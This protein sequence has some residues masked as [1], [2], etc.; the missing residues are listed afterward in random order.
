MNIQRSLVSQ[1]IK[2]SITIPAE[3]EYWDG[4]VET[5][6]GES[7]RPIN[8]KFN[9]PIDWDKITEDAS[10]ALAE[11]YMDKKVEL[12]DPSRLQELVVNVFGNSGSFLRDNKFIGNLF[13][14]KNTKKSSSEDIKSHYDIGN[15]FYELWLDDSM[16]YS[17]A[18]FKTKEDTLEQAQK[19]KLHHIYNKLRLNEND[20]LLDIGCG[21][22]DLILM[23]AE[24]F[25]LKATGVTLSE[26]QH[27]HV[28]SEIKKRGLEDRVTV[29]L[30]DYRDLP[31]EKR[32]F[33]KIA[34]VGM[35]EHVGRSNLQEYYEIINK[36]LE[37]N[38]MALIHGISGQR[39]MY[40]EETGSNAF[41]LKYIFPGGY[42]PSVGELVDYPT[43]LKMHV[44]DVESIRRHYQLTLEEW[45]NR[46][47]KNIDKIKDLGKY[48][49]RFLRMWDVYLQSCAAVFQSGNTDVNQ[50][51]I[52]KGTDNSRPLTREYML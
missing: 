33:T 30:K 7:N 11:A 10:L 17:C 29:E 52:E 13:R 41:L 15:D 31:K 28:Q 18:Y 47:Y 44:I 19:Q 40:D 45:H 9:E 22:G 37:D 23:A 3:V 51:L 25:G 8:I 21:W 12:E 5:Y 20:T 32:K 43:R 46:F 14:K 16:T 49:E 50:Y 4:K 48:D 34:S 24:K 6:G 35:V 42:I 2:N 39:D 26:E 27:A 38:G 36:L 1:L